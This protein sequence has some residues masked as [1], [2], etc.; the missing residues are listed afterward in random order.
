[1][2]SNRGGGEEIWREQN[3]QMRDQEPNKSYTTYSF[4]SR[5]FYKLTSHVCIFIYLVTLFFSFVNMYQTRTQ[6]Y[7]LISDAASKCHATENTTSEH[8]NVR[9]CK[10]LLT[11]TVELY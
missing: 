6:C 8:F 5:S 9:E 7:H 1:M 10:E 11:V 4:N 2:S 3:A